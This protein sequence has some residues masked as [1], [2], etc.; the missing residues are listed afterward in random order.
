M[1]IRYNGGGGGGGSAVTF[2]GGGRG[3]GKNGGVWGDSLLRETGRS[4]ASSRESS[5]ISLV[6]I[7][8][9]LFFFR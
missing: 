1:G 2:S 4:V 8:A 5:F 6:F 3:S 9:F 7:L